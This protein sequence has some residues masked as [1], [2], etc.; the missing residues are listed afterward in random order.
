MSVREM[1]NWG[2]VSPP[3]LRPPP[4]PEPRLPGRRPGDGRLCYRKPAPGSITPPAGRRLSRLPLASQL[5]AATGITAA[6]P[7]L[8][9]PTATPPP[10]SSV[11]P[12]HLPPRPVSLPRVP[13]LLSRARHQSSRR[14]SRQMLAFAK[15]K[16]VASGRLTTEHTSHRGTE[17]VAETGPNPPP[18]PLTPQPCQASPSHHAVLNCQS[19]NPFWQDGGGIG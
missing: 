18:P 4:R 9:P 3:L 2:S 5:P 8:T 16:S 19:P 1:H 14:D 10:P 12:L 11:P 7:P 17:A 13:L 6:Q 15:I